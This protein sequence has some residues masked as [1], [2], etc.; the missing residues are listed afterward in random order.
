[1]ITDACFEGA[2]ATFRFEG[3]SKI[4]DIYE[5]IDEIEKCLGKYQ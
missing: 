3:E 5:Y 4:Y 1:M 2:K